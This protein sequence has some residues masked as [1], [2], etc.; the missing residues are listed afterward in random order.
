MDDGH[1]CFGRH[2]VYDERFRPVSEIVHAHQHNL[3]AGDLGDL[4]VAQGR[5]RVRRI[6]MAGEDR[7]AGAMVAVRER[8]ARVICRRHHR[9]NAGH[10]LERDFFRREHFGFLAAT[11]ED[12]RVAAFEPHDGLALAGAGEHEFGELFLYEAAIALVVAA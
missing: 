2:A 8:D 11:T 10:D 12:K 4:L 6:A 1:G 5:G 9:G 7:E 3:G